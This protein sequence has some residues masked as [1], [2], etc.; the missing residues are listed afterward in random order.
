MS[1]SNSL[2]P[3]T[4]FW[5]WSDVSVVE[6]LSPDWNQLPLI[7]RWMHHKKDKEELGQDKHQQP[8]NSN[9]SY[10]KP[11]LQSYLLRHQG[12]RKEGR[13]NRLKSCHI[14]WWRFHVTLTA[15]TALRR[16]FNCSKTFKLILKTRQIL[17]KLCYDFQVVNWRLEEETFERL[18]EPRPLN[19]TT[20]A[21]W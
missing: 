18:K 1:S 16:M 21:L 4:G 14:N 9:I 17:E 5:V 6:M 11:E 10:K 2:N 15:F 3:I 13:K 8:I 7:L 12:C 20:H 19:L